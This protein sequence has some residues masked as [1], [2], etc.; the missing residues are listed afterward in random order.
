MA[1][2]VLE[3]GSFRGVFSAG[4][5]DA[6]LDYDIYFN[7]VI[8][9]SAGISNGASYVSKQKGRNIEIMRKY[10]NDKR[11]ISKRNYLKHHSLFGLDFVYDELP[12]KLIP[13]DWDSYYSFDGVMKVGVTDAV[14]GESV[15]KNGIETDRK[16]TM[17]RATCAIP[18]FFPPIELDGRLYF[19]GGISDP[20]PIK[21]SIADGN[22]TNLVILTQPR[23]YIKKQGKAGKFAASRYKKKFP[24]LSKAILNRPRIYNDT[25]EYIKKHSRENPD[26]I[27]VL[28]PAYKLKS[29]ESDMQ[30]LEQIYKHGYDVALENMDKIRALVSR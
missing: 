17:F 6:L 10:R 30:K 19:D 7:Y 24:G 2:L 27:V 14:T 18:M 3:G 26:D 5:I 4:V 16:C 20:I 12:N 28:N 11:Y 15:F 1:G 25:I 22:K 21:R 8:G 9:V 13:I 23:G 29:F